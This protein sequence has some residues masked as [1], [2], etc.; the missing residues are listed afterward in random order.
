MTKRDPEAEALAV[1]DSCHHQLVHGHQ[2]CDACRRKAI[3]T[4]LHAARQ[5]ERER[6]EVLLEAWG[7]SWDC[8]ADPG[9]R[10]FHQAIETYVHDTATLAARPSATPADAQHVHGSGCIY[11]YPDCEPQPTDAPDEPNGI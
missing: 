11:T 7:R 10:L 3:T 8:S 2:V 6:T 4:A 5:A 9:H 1:M